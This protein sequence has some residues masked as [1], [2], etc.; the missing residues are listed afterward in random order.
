MAEYIERAGIIT[1]FHRLGLGENGLVE[2][3]FADGVYAVLETF[4]AAD[5]VPA[6]HGRLG[7]NSG[8]EPVDVQA[9]LNFLRGYA[10]ED[11]EQVYTNGSILVPLFRVEQALIDRAYNGF[12][13]G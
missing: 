11:K 13:E 4:P 2:K 6:R 9:A 1:E 12:M 8:G 7:E 3:I 10:I 5:V